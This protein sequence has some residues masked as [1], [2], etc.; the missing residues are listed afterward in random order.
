MESTMNEIDTTST[1]S[2]D[3]TVAD[4]RVQHIAQVM[5]RT[6]EDVLAF[7]QDQ[8]VAEGDTVTEELDAGEDVAEIIEALA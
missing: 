8:A 5:Q 3:P 4:P 1:N 6:P 7:A 2:T